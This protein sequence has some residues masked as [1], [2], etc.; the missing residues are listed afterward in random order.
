MGL[1]VNCSLFCNYSLKLLKLMCYNL[2]S[3]QY[4]VHWL[5][6]YNIVYKSCK[7]NLLTLLTKR[8]NQI[9][10]SLLAYWCIY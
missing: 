1:I 3:S 9:I 5:G 4:Y 2:Y 10:S 8:T 6:T 7:T